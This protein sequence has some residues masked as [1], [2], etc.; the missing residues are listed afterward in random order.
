MVFSFV[1]TS[2]PRQSSIGF[3][4]VYDITRHFLPFVGCP[5]HIL[6]EPGLTLGEDSQMATMDVLR[7]RNHSYLSIGHRTQ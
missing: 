1:A 7:I 3:A 5:P 6:T 2:Y 4:V